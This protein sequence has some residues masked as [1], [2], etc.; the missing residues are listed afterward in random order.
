MTYRN[1]V[2]SIPVPIDD[3]TITYRNMVLS[4]PVPIDDLP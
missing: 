2:L 3:F 1:M 4:I